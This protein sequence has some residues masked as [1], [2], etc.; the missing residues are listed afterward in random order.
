MALVEVIMQ[1][2]VKHP[3][4]RMLVCA[5]SGAALDHILHQLVRSEHAATVWEAASWVRLVENI[6]DANRSPADLHQFFRHFG[7]GIHERIIFVTCKTA[8][9]LPESYRLVFDRITHVIV[10]EAHSATEPECIVPIA[11]THA[12][13]DMQ[14][15]LSGDIF[16]LRPRVVSQLARNYG[17]DVSYSLDLYR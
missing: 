6:D 8:G 17:L 16:Q 4:S 14:I 11:C 3:S 1:L 10:D 9:N 5:T 2:A 12:V 13:G 7:Q 15:V